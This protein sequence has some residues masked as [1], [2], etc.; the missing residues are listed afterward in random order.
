L[1]LLLLALE[2]RLWSL[3]RSVDIGQKGLSGIAL[4]RGLAR[5]YPFVLKN[6][7]HYFQNLCRREALGTNSVAPYAA[8]FYATCRCNLDCIYC[9]QKEPDVFSQELPTEKT[10][11]L[12]R[13]MR[14]ETDSILFSGGEPTLR[15]DIEELT[16]AAREDLKF[17][18]VLLVTNGTLLHKRQK[19][20][21]N[22]HGLI[23]SLDSLAVDCRRPMSKPAVVQR[24][25]DN[26]QL[27]RS[28]MPRPTDITINTVVEEWNIAEIE[29]IL[30]YCGEQGFVFATQSAL[31]EKMPNLRLRQNPRYQALVQRLVARSTR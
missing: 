7:R 23:V 18:S 12:L 10:I 28:R 9:T 27:V 20:L 1:R 16:H 3:S 22:L 30:K 21:E 6:F 24:V 25:L 17:R 11:E 2:L 26:L 29:H 14:R 19:L 4:L 31:Q 13:A 8:V 5:R 15:N